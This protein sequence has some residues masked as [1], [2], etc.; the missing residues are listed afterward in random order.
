MSVEHRHAHLQD[1]NAKPP[2]TKLDRLKAIWHSLLP[3]RQLVIKAGSISVKPVA[4]GGK[5]YDASELSDG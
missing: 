5:D 2:K 3:H 1:A 4:A